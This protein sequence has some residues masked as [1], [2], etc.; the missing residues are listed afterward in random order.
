MKR[1]LLV[2]VGAALGWYGHSKLSKGRDEAAI[3]A[4]E[5]LR[6]SLAPENIGRSIGEGAAQ[7]IV[8][9]TKA[10]FTTVRDQIPALNRAEPAPP[11]VE[12]P[13]GVEPLQGE[14]TNVA[15]VRAE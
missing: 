3:R 13:N 5:A 9:S 14:V 2:G 7:I 6:T 10:F 8:E 4:E 11:I 12:K 15:S 1:V